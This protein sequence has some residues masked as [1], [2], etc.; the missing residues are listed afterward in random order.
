VKT[1]IT[2]CSQRK[3]RPRKGTQYTV[4]GKSEESTLKI[5]DRKTGG[6]RGSPKNKNQ[7]QISDP[8]LGRVGKVIA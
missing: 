5:V 7:A 4:I 6:S 1:P 2:K 8:P 3:S